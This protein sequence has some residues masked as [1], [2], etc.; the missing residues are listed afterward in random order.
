MFLILLFDTI[1]LNK[2][3][4]PG[5][6]EMNWVNI[7]TKHEWSHLIIKIN[8]MAK[9]MHIK[10]MIICCRQKDKKYIRN[11]NKDCPVVHLSLSNRESTK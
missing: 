3:I 6:S 1:R 7:C 2:I 11:K 9:Y 8:L 4:Y 5:G 10:C